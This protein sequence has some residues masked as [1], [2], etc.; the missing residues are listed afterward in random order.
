MAGRREGD[1]RWA[2]RGHPS[3][4]APG[5]P[6]GEMECMR[7]LRWFLA[8]IPLTPTPAD[9]ESWLGR[10]LYPSRFEQLPLL[11]DPRM[12][13]RPISDRVRRWRTGWRAIRGTHGARLRSTAALVR[14]AR[15]TTARSTIFALGVGHPRGARLASLRWSAVLGADG[16]TYTLSF[17][18]KTCRVRRHGAPG[19]SDTDAPSSSHTTPT[20][21]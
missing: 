16:R 10:P 14:M 11:P 9:P 19:G 18:W 4:Y 5:V 21:D 2:Y 7:I 8:S 12:W 15:R 6:I 1:P 3:L 13:P 20:E 17:D